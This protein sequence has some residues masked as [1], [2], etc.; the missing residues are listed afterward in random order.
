MEDDTANTIGELTSTQRRA[1]RVN[2][3][4]WNEQYQ[5]LGRRVADP[6]SDEWELVEGFSGEGCGD[7]IGNN[8]KY[9]NGRK[10]AVKSDQA[11]P[12]K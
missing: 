8:F 2:R 10:I 5:R 9:V 11:N 7:V 12:G 6:E 1:F 3:K 4:L